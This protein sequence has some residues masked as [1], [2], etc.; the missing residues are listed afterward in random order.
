MTQTLRLLVPLAALAAALAP[1]S[2]EPT[3]Q[4]SPHAPY[5]L[6]ASRT[7]PA[8][9]DEDYR[10]Q[11]PQYVLSYNGDKLRPNWVAWRLEADD[12]G[13]S[14]RG[15]FEPDPLLPR[16][17]AKVTTHDYDGSGFDRGHMCPAQD[18]SGQQKDMDATFYLTN[19]VP[20]APNCNQ[21]GWER[22][23][24]YCRELAKQGHTLYIVSGP[25]GKGG[26]GKDGRKDEVGRGRHKIEVPHKVWKV[27]LVVPRQD[28]E[29]RRNTRAIA[30]IMPNDQSVD[31][32][33]TKYR[34]AVKDVE[35]LTGYR[36]FPNVDKEVADAIK[37]EPD[38]VKV[39]VPRPRR[40][41]SK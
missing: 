23:E 11:R 5:G 34:V 33:W 15:P 3:R 13:K 27:I 8:A 22:L 12:L 29:L 24:T 35:K 36:F 21:R 32:D 2:A 16:D 20:Q 41:S 25:A 38:D 40:E 28:A 17:I 37:A 1:L 26:E 10:I 6:P 30:V 31:F 7:R 4:V 14:S 9:E 39:R 18:R 19:I